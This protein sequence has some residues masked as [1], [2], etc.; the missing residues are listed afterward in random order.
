MSQTLSFVC[1]IWMISMLSL[2]QKFQIDERVVK[3][4]EYALQQYDVVSNNNVIKWK[5][6]WSGLSITEINQNKERYY[7]LAESKCFNEE[8]NDDKLLK[9]FHAQ[10]N[11]IQNSATEAIIEKFKHSP[12]KSWFQMFDTKD[13]GSSRLGI[14]AII[15]DIDDS[16]DSCI[17]NKCFSTKSKKYKLLMA[18]RQAKWDIVYKSKRK[19]IPIL[20]KPAKKI[21]INDNGTMNDTKSVIHNKYKIEFFKEIIQQY[22]NNGFVGFKSNEQNIMNITINI[23]NDFTFSPNTGINLDFKQI[24]D[25]FEGNSDI[26]VTQS[27]ATIYL[28]TDKAFRFSANISIFIDFINNNC[29]I[30]MKRINQITKIKCSG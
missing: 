14:F 5:Q 25:I 13:E 4:V 3:Q 11:I 24:Y 1:S 21:K 23:S 26:E 15:D 28:K 19:Y 20:G 17:S 9:W 8:F 7:Q 22:P 12:S 16:C 2:A 18:C 6:V 27:N 29:H 10:T 30:F